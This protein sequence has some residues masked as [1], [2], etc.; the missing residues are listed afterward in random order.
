MRTI[1]SLAIA[2]AASIPSATSFAT[3]YNLP[4]DLPPEVLF[5][6][7]TMNVFVGA[8][9]AE[10]IEARAGSTINLY[11]GEMGILT[12]L[13]GNLNIYSGKASSTTVADGGTINVYNGSTDDLHLANSVLNLHGGQI[14]GLVWASS[15]TINM[16]A[17]AFP[18]FRLIDSTVNMTGGKIVF[19]LPAENVGVRSTLNVSGGELGTLYLSDGSD[20]NLRGGSVVPNERFA[21]MPDA[22]AYLYVRSALLNGATVPGLTHGVAVPID[23]TN[24]NGQLDVVLQNGSPFNFT[25]SALPFSESNPGPAGAVISTNPSNTGPRPPVAKV[26]VFITLIPEPSTAT[27]AAVG[28]VACS[29][30]IRRLRSSSTRF[31]VC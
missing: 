15:S 10:P 31:E 3:V 5:A 29:A 7:D 13:Y 24:V 6:G 12:Y 8:A 14:N 20:L 9:K 19:G 21:V 18:F 1:T 11:G 25:L 30:T 2:L 26:E 23:V 16:A 28:V 4:P 22:T 27:M 17:G